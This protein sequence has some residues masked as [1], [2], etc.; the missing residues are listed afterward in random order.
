MSFLIQSNRA[1]IIDSKKI[2][3]YT[4][5]KIN[6]PRR[7]DLFFNQYYRKQSLELINSLEDYLIN[8]IDNRYF[9]EESNI[10]YFHEQDIK[11][12]INQL[13]K[14]INNLNVDINTKRD[15]YIKLDLENKKIQNIN[16]ILN[17]TNKDL[18]N[19]IDIISKELLNFEKNIDIHLTKRTHQIHND[20]I[21]NNYTIKILR[22]LIYFLIIKI[23]FIGY[24][25]FVKYCTG[26]YLIIKYL[27]YYSR[28]IFLNTIYCIPI[29]KSTIISMLGLCGSFIYYTYTYIKIDILNNNS[30][31]SSELFPN[32]YI[33]NSMNM[34][35]AK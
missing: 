20:C 6:R 33:N 7:L 1:V 23:F 19:N 22:Y 14:N 28:I 10:K 5:L 29:Y 30:I 31:T 16:K 3:N 24:F 2:S 18:Q 13:L 12:I 11:E 27:Y 8:M 17:E 26:I 34:C 9:I 4:R 15:R 21:Q 32:T 25:G 35:Y